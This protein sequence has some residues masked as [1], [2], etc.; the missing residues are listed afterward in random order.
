M[1]AR[2]QPVN[3]ELLHRRALAIREKA[4]GP[5]HPDLTHSLE[6][7]ALLQQ[8][9]GRHTQAELLL[10]RS[11]PDAWAAARRGVLDVWF[12]LPAR[13]V[14]RHGEPVLIDAGGEPMN[15]TLA[16][17]ARERDDRPVVLNE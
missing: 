13:N 8:D 6:S 11:P 1:Q 14:D 5:N 3:S 7:L 2:R 15:A 17:L 4:L 16:R 10:R 12:D 9:Q